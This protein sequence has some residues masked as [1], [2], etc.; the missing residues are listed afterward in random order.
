MMASGIVFD[1][2]GELL[3]SERGGKYLQ[4]FQVPYKVIDLQKAHI[5]RKGGEVIIRNQYS[6]N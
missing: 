5:S 1:L 6:E 3:T 2:P 4:K